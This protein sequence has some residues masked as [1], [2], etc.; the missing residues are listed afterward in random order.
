MGKAINLPKDAV[1]PRETKKRKTTK[2]SSRKK[3]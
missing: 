3:S 1:P 2:K